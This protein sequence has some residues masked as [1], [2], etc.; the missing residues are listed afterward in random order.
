M[1]GLMFL[2]RDSEPRTLCPGCSRMR[3]KP[4]HHHIAKKLKFIYRLLLGSYTCYSFSLYWFF[5]S[6][7][8]FLGLCSGVDSFDAS[9]CNHCG[10]AATTSVLHSAC[11]SSPAQR[12]LSVSEITISLLVE[13][14]VWEKIDDA[15]RF[16]TF[17]VIA[18]CGVF[19]S[20]LIDSK[21]GVSLSQ[22]KMLLVY[23][24]DIYVCTCNFTLLLIRQNFAE[25]LNT[26][27]H[28]FADLI[29]GYHLVSGIY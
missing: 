6:G 29:Y 1:D 19:T 26:K 20:S 25:C 3:H 4:L 10:S 14:Y 23:M 8:S 16:S 5:C 24:D 28:R 2:V 17:R 7:R 18:S 21:G 27:M 15:S 9:F 11:I 13:D 22:C 12:L